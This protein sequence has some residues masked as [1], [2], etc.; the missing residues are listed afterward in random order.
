MLAKKRAQVESD[1]VKS[2]NFR[3]ERVPLLSRLGE[4]DRLVR[5]Y[6]RAVQT[7]AAEVVE[8]LE[9]MA[10]EKQ[11]DRRR[12][13]ALEARGKLPYRA[14]T[15]PDV[16]G[17]SRD[18]PASPRGGAPRA[19]SSPSPRYVGTIP[20]FRG[21][22]GSVAQEERARHR[23]NCGFRG[24]SSSRS[25]SQSRLRGPRARGGNKPHH[26]SSAGARDVNGD[27]VVSHPPQDR[28]SRAGAGQRAR[29]S[30]HRSK[31]DSHGRSFG[32][33]STFD[34]SEDGQWDEQEEG[35]EE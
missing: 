11:E 35:G 19:I 26:H 30:G 28:G 24:G 7:G 22:R 31:V 1:R 16:A 2:V 12:Q 29:Y 34:W 21:D 33:D 10:R 23:E 27:R 25:R 13:I 15:S 20:K 14:I 18:G 4:V 6:D 9:K 5:N 8:M 17:H 32:E 3:E